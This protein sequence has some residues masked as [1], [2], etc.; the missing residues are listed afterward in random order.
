MT[1]TRSRVMSR[2][3]QRRVD[4]MLDQKPGLQLIG[5]DHVGDDEEIHV[6]AVF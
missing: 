5:S 3:H 4:Q 2:T 6:S 1:G